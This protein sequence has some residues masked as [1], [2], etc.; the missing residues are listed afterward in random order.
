[1]PAVG[2][3]LR[4]SI[5]YNGVSA[6]G[7]E[8]FAE[9]IQ[10]IAKA[11][12]EK[13][14]SAKANTQAMREEWEGQMRDARSEVMKILRE[15]VK[16]ALD[17]YAKGLEGIV[18]AS[19]VEALEINGFPGARCSS[20]NQNP[21]KCATT[22]IWA[23]IS[24]NPDDTPTPQISFLV[25]CCLQTVDKDSKWI[26]GKALHS[27]GSD[28]RMARM[29]GSLDRYAINGWCERELEQCTRAYVRESA[30]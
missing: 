12:Q 13:I 11:E 6:M 9:R 2:P 19:K 17:E 23:V 10:R 27:T 14:A 28:N 7:D 5:Y 20:I 22:E 3:G 16:P 30:A 26:E 24:G 8:S 29:A 15:I 21:K 1:M 4:R 18:V 25:K